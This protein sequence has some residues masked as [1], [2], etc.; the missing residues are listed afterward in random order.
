MGRAIPVPSSDK[1]TGIDRVV[2]WEREGLI[3]A[4]SWRNSSQHGFSRKITTIPGI[5]GNEFL[6][7]L[8][9]CSFP[10]LVQL[11]PLPPNGNPN[12]KES[13]Y[14]QRKYSHG[15]LLPRSWE[16]RSP[17]ILAPTYRHGSLLC[18][19]RDELLTP[20]WGGNREYHYPV[21]LEH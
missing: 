21:A 3:P 14:F 18:V 5:P 16:G 20:G 9:S 1:E 7:K 19:W 4:G 8:L 12:S 6:I 11:F 15:L 13:C 10:A 2:F 17:E